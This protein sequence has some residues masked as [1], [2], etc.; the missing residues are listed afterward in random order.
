MQ[1]NHFDMLPD[2]AFQPVGKRMT[3]EGG[4][5]KGSYTPPPPAPAAEP[6]N[7]QAAV[8]PATEAGNTT[9]NDNAS[10][11]ANRTGKSSLRIDLDPLTASKNQGAAGGSGLAISG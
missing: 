4:G 2:L 11:N 7:T 3:L 8:A 5:G 6:T 10:V 1:Y 9:N